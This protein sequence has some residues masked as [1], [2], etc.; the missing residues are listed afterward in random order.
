M[1]SVVGAG[2]VVPSDDKGLLVCKS[3]CR[4]SPLSRGEQAGDTAAWLGMAELIM[5]AL[6]ALAVDALRKCLIVDVMLCI[7]MRSIQI[8]ACCADRCLIGVSLR[9]SSSS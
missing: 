2:I 9:T 8:I 6:C 4:P 3:K 7:S 1:D 5:L